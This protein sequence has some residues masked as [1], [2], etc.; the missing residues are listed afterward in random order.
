MKKIATLVICIVGISGINSSSISQTKSSSVQIF[1]NPVLP[2]GPDPWAIYHNGYYYYMNTL[3]NRLAIWKTRD[4]A[5]LKSAQKK[6]IWKAP[7]HGNYSHDIWAPELH[8][9]NV[10]WYVYF[11]ADDGHNKTHRIY[12]LE[13]DAADPLK[14]HWVFKGKTA[15]PSDKWAIDASV[16][17]YHHQLYM[18]WSGW[19]GDQ[20]GQQNI[21]IA[22]MKNPYTI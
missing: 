11:A 19:K 4:L 2:S 12:V 7:K 22:K 10:K 3:R 1:T 13:N 8:Y 21:Y 14:G 20:N 15:A 17:K 6:V 18:I 5:F 9:L 16:F